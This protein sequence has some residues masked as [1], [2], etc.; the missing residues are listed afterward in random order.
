MDPVPF[1]SLLTFCICWSEFDSI[2]SDSESAGNV[3]VS[4]DAGSKT[5]SI[6]SSD[7]V[8]FC[9]IHSDNCK[10]CKDR[11]LKGVTLLFHNV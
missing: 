11:W 7:K 5:S 9:K 1:S 4:H 2:D 6:L 8:I 3:T 10:R